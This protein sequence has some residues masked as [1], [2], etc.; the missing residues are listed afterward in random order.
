M[1][2]QNKSLG[3]FVLD[4]IPPAPRGV[5]QVEV[6]FDIDAN[7]ILKVTAKDKATGRSQHITI[8]A[9][10]GLSDTEIEQ[11]RRE[12]E[13]HAEEDRLR[14]ENIEVRNQADN[15]IY[16]AEKALRDFGDKIPADVKSTVEDKVT[17]TRKALDL[18]D[19]ATI[20][21]ATEDLGQVIQSIGAAA[22]GASDGAPGAAPGGDGNTPPPGAPDEDVIEG[23]FRES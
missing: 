15:M 3:K 11:M 20:K 4:G 8:T 10:S 12:A 7:G 14:K 13:A 1:A 16:T 23:E 17:E 2:A 5:P 9:S 19:T 6:T 21:K 18:N 22:Y